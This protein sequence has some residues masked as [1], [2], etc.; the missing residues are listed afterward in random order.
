MP[1]ARPRSIGTAC[2]D[3]IAF[4]LQRLSMLRAVGQV[5]YDMG[6]DTALRFNLEKC[7]AIPLWRIW[8]PEAEPRLSIVIAHIDPKLIGIPIPPRFGLYGHPQRCLR[9]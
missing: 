7:V 3:D 5:F 9:G 1:R 4:V 2:A 8:A 6:R